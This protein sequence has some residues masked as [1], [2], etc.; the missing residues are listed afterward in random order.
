M[1]N[2]L[3]FKVTL[4]EGVFDKNI[5]KAFF[6]AGGPGSGKSFVTK[7]AFAGTGLKFVNSDRA[8]ENNLKQ[9]NL[10]MKMPD[11]EAYF[12]D[13]LRKRAKSVT[14][15]MM[16]NYVEGRLG[17]VIDGTARDYDLVSSQF[18]SLTALGYDCY[19]I[20]IN[21]TLNVALERNQTRSR[22]VPEYIVKKSW[23]TVQSNIGQ[24]QRLFGLSNFIIIDN[25][26][27]EQELINQ[28]LNRANKLIGQ[29]LKTP[30]K[31]YIGKNWISKELQA[32]KRM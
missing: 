18:Q 30:V 7:N 2:F 13:L 28:T 9:A 26:K 8:F 17:L 16:D 27:S 5:L 6:L 25:N 23:D 11:E 19:M 14:N 22:S 29:Y 32:R 15:R 21:T 31:N 10:S 12:R 4:Q 1:K 3:D 24:Y 20:F